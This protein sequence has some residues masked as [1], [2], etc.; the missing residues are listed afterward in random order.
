M[1][2][3]NHIYWKQKGEFALTEDIYTTWVAFAVE[4]GIFHY[5]IG[6]QIGEASFGDL[7]LCPRRFL[8]GGQSLPR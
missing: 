7:V 4:E 3:L 5:E 1:E 2:L 6:G 8:F